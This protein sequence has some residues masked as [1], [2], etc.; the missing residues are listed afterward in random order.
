MFLVRPNK[1]I[2]T[3]VNLPEALLKS[4]KINVEVDF[5][6]EGTQV[7]VG[8]MYLHQTL[9]ISTSTLGRLHILYHI[10]TNFYCLR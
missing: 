5:S 7:W 2:C 10:V 1:F 6:L 3:S 8:V 4:A 9:L